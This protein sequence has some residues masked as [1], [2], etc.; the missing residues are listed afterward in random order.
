LDGATAMGAALPLPFRSPAMRAL[1][2]IAFLAAAA[3]TAAGAE[4]YRQGPVVV[5]QAWS[6][7]AA[8]GT[9]AAGYMVVANHGSAPV[10]VN[11]VE[12]P[13]A[14]KV[15]MHQSTMTGGV[16]SMKRVES[17][18]VPAGG[19][20]TFAPG[21]YHLMFFGLIKP[22]KTG[23]VLPATLAFADGRRLKIAF[24]VGA[25]PVKIPAKAMETMDMGDMDHMAH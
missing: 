16:M 22:L 6:R 1:A 10:T 3:A 24:T 8:V 15:E 4:A 19:A 18:L 20:V 2:S 17:L 14:R 5:D 12:S 9:N 13:A 23:E 7:P 11:A 25:G 21:G